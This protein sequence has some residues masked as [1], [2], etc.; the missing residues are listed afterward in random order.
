MKVLITGVSGLAGSYLARYLLENV[1][2][3]SLYGTIRWRSRIDNIRSL[4]DKINLTECDIRDMVSV[5]ELIGGIKPD[6]IFHM[7]SQSSVFASW[8]APGE[9]MTT[10][11]LG[12]VNF[13]EA[14][15]D[16][17][18]DAK[19]LIP[20]SSEEY[21]LAESSDL[22]LK[23]DVHFHPLS[24]YAVSKVVQDMA[25]YQY[26]NSYGLNIYRIRAFNHTGPSREPNFVESNFARRIAL[27]EKDKADPVIMVGNLKARRDYTDV[28]DMV[29]AY[30][31]AV[32]RCQPGI[33]YNVC[34]GNVLSI[35]EILNILLSF[36]SRKIAVEAD[37]ERLR[38]ADA[39]DIY[40]DGSLFKK[41]TGWEPEIPF[42]ETLREILEYWRQRV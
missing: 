35:G 21:G 39:P 34:S 7:A 37:P 23:E 11:I 12:A 5:R 10:N 36:T 2:E 29:R 20:C 24:P 4:M 3:V 41:T 31:L 26:H 9:T 42:R 33:V 13:F 38:P 8:H 17:A 32:N 22:P 18:P 25:G 16:L 19:I 1:P 40:G 30:W 14:M 15:R 6:V 28:R 27:I